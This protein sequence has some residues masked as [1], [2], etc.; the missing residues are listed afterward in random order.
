MLVIGACDSGSASAP[1]ET[2]PAESP[3]AAAKA[4]PE[5][6][7][8]AAPK[9]AAPDGTTLI[10]EL[11]VHTCAEPGSCPQLMHAEGASHCAALDLAGMTWRL[12]SVTELE[13]WRGHEA[14]TGFDV[15]HWSGT[16]WED[17]AGQVWIYDPGS[18]AKTTA[19][20]TRKPFTIR[21]VA[22]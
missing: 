6:P 17:D 13:S 8:A 18:G 10:G 9:P 2:P 16:A 12:P 21:C 22:S 5:Q 7:A 20:P 14:L 3:A 11:Y 1:A 19:K 4:A 15:F